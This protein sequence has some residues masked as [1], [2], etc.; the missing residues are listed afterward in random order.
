MN[1]L[2]V[3]PMREPRAIQID[4][5]LE[6][7]QKAVGGYI[8]AV[9]PFDDPVAVIVNDEGKINGL[10]LNRA[11]RDEAGEI[12]DVMAGQ[13]LV[14]GLGKE[15]FSDLPPDMMEKYKKHFKN[16]EMFLR[17]GGRIVAVKCPVSE[18]KNKTATRTMGNDA[19]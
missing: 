5:G 19:R 10:P 3:E 4:S 15:N 7:L 6:S 14:V 13:F 2:L 11:L 18:V 1:V 12:Y 17:L 9:Y 8:E 16:P